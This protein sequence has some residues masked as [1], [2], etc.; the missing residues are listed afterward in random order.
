M[1]YFLQEVE[2][3]I[4]KG[5]GQRLFYFS[6]LVIILLSGLFPQQLINAQ[7]ESQ[8]NSLLAKAEVQ[9]KVSGELSQEAYYNQFAQ[10]NEKQNQAWNVKHQFRPETNVVK[11]ANWAEFKTA[12]VDNNVSKIILTGAIQQEGKVQ[13][14]SRRE[15]LEIDG[16]GYLLRMNRGSLN[17]TGEGGLNSLAEFPGKFSSR[18]VFHFHDLELSNGSFG[19]VGG[20]Y[21][22]INPDDNLPGVESRGLWHYRIGNLRTPFVAGDPPQQTIRGRL[23][24][25]N[26]AEIT[27]W[28]Y[29]QIVTARENFYAGSIKIEPFTY[30]YG[31]TTAYSVPVIWF[32]DDIPNQQDFTG[33]KK[34]NVGEGSFVYLVGNQRSENYPAIYGHWNQIKVNPKGTLNLNTL[35]PALIFSEDFSQFVGAEESTVNLVSRGANVSTVQLR[36]KIEGESETP[37]GI[38]FEMKPNS[39][40]FAAGSSAYGVFAYGNNN[41]VSSIDGT[42]NHFI[43]DSLANYDIRNFWPQGGPFIGNNV[44]PATRGSQSFQLRNSD[45]FAWSLSTNLANKFDLGGQ[46]VA[47]L[48]ISTAID[49]SEVNSSDPMVAAELKPQQIKRLTGGNSPATFIWAPVTDAD[50]SQ[51]G[52]V[53]LGQTPLEYYNLSQA[54]DAFGNLKLKPLYA[55]QDFLAQVDFYDT[56]G[57]QFT[58]ESGAEQEIMWSAANHETPGFQVAGKKLSAQAYRVQEING[59][60]HLYR[61]GELAEALVLDVT[62]PEPARI[63]NEAILTSTKQ[64][65]GYQAEV[66]AQVY[67][68]SA[69]KLIG[70]TVVGSEGEWVFDLPRYLTPEDHLIIYLEDQAGLLNPE[71][72]PIPPLTNNSRGNINPQRKPLAYRERIFPPASE[73]YIVDDRPPKPEIDLKVSLKENVANRQKTTQVGSRLFYQAKIKNPAPLGTRKTLYSSRYTYEVSEGLAL[74]LT[75]FSGTRNGIALPETAFVKDGDQVFVELGALAPADEIQLTY[76]GLVTEEALGKE[77]KH[78]GKISGQSLQL[79]NFEPGPIKP[80]ATFKKMEAATTISNPG[81]SVSGTLKF[82]SVPKVIDFGQVKY[83]GEKISLAHPLLSQELV[84]VDQRKK[85]L[86]WS[87]TVELADKHLPTNKL[88]LVNRLRY[89]TPDLTEQLILEGEPLVAFRSQ[90]E[91]F[92]NVSQT[93]QQQNQGLKLVLNSPTSEMI[94]EYQGELIWRL[95]SGPRGK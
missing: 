78:R 39:N 57:N 76:Q 30:Y 92:V 44:H 29:N 10:L 70:T 83:Q 73:F 28:G 5:W 94:G 7:L 75:S 68:V 55:D 91:D 52:Q 88:S 95:V 34:F 13:T 15:S 25:G 19:Q 90:G 60:R 36:S 3:M 40:L 82:A 31:A 45:L 48:I 80:G 87:L 79:E 11:V 49:T 63:S 61:K 17:L 89:I 27:L 71:L 47:E 23:I 9:A 53:I 24:G 59:N 81:G 72:I 58:S 84:V 20:E 12:F 41:L 50:L 22:F 56:L 4:S 86:P 6:Q 1:G 64:I 38:K 35:G 85:L 37:K 46:N 2:G 51:R 26:Q 93:W 42:N 32:I 43:L 77:I 33:T 69:D 18:P 66:G 67:I 16:Q 54:T 74:D 21:N 65:F 14:F 8:N 62:P